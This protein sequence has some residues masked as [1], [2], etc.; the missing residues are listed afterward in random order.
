MFIVTRSHWPHY[1]YMLPWDYQTGEF[2]TYGEGCSTAF[3]RVFAAAGWA[4]ELKTM[5]STAVKEALTLAVDTGKPLVD[6]LNKV[7]LEY[8]K[9]TSDDHVLEYRKYK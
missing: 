4:S 7:G 6:C 2:G 1:H 3:I 9:K 5:D 8:A